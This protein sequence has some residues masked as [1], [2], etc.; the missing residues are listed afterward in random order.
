MKAT[1]VW[2]KNSNVADVTCY[3]PPPSPNFGPT[4]LRW[5]DPQ[6]LGGEQIRLRLS[7]WT[8]RGR[9]DTAIVPVSAGGA[10]ER[11]GQHE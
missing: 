5:R 9:H 3:A 8:L 11:R 2:S 4:V 7:F 1:P 10:M 6:L